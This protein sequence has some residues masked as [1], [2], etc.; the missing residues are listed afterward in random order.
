V[1]EGDEVLAWEGLQELCHFIED[2]ELF[3]VPV[4]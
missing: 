3:L 4:G 2:V 1:M